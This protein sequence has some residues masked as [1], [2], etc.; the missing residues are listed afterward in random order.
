MDIEKAPSIGPKMA[1]R[2]FVYRIE[3]VGDLLGAEPET[4]SL[5]LNQR[6][7]DAETIKDWQSQAALCCDVPNLR[8]H[9]AQILT[10]CGIRDRKSLA[11]AD[12]AKLLK[13]VETF[14]ETTAGK[15]ILR[16]GAKPDMEEVADWIAWA[17]ET[18]KSQAA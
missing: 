9:D 14:V 8:G 3:T 1:A 13:Q 7:V 10:A 4:L 11:A 17:N 15:R 2:L 16:D 18:P 5:N 12:Q 6:S